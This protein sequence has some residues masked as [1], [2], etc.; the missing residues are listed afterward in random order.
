MAKNKSVYFTLLVLFTCICSYSQ[1]PLRQSVE[2]NALAQVG[3]REL[4]GSNDGKAVES[5]LATCGLKKGNAWCAAFV[6]FCYVKSGV[7]T[8]NSAWAP[9]WHPSS[10]IIWKQGTHLQQLPQVADVFG[11]WINGRIGHVG[12]IQ[13][14]N[15]KIVTTIE[16]NTNEAGSREGDGVYKKFRLTKQIYCVS[17]WLD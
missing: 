14:W 2:A 9:A 3:V 6:N 11:L 8:I 4:T 7:K 10:K 17:K 15:T 12:I 5:Y 13:K 16:G 1:S